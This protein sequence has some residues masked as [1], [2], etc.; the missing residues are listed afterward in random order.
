M[1]FVSFIHVKQGITWGRPGQLARPGT[2][3]APPAQ[4]PEGE[5]ASRQGRC[6]CEGEGGGAPSPGTRRRLGREREGRYY[7][8][9]SEKNRLWDRTVLGVDLR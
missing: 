2:A 1:A 5:G 3:R 8:F 6:P 9:L 4:A 7:C